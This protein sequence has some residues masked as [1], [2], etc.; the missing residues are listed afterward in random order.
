MKK[1]IYYKKQLDEVESRIKSTS[2]AIKKLKNDKDIEETQKRETLAL[3]K[4]SKKALKATY[5]ELMLAI[6]MIQVG[7]TINGLNDLVEPWTMEELQHQI[8][9][10]ATQTPML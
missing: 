3:L 9:N 1:I 7:D 4:D 10:K 2:K 8:D 5:L 6:H